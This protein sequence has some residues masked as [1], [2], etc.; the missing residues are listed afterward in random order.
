M[1]P[2]AITNGAVPTAGETVSSIIPL[3]QPKKAK[4]GAERSRAYRQRKRP[5]RKAAA[6]T[7]DESPSSE[8]L[9]PEGFLSADRAFAEPAVALPPT[10]PVHDV[11]RDEDAPSRSI[12]RILLVA[13]ALAL[14]AVG[15]AMNGWFARSLGASDA[16]GWLFLAIGVAADLVALVVPSCA[17]G[18]WQARHRAASLAGWAVWAMTFLF[19]VTAGIGFASTNISDVTLTRF[20]SFPLTL[21]CFE[22][23]SG[24]SETVDS[25]SVEF[26][27][28]HCHIAI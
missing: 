1:S 24:H 14:A 8:L 15:I 26:R 5:K 11:A 4:S 21:D 6:P 3:H 17:A 13:A 18:L 28:L 9:I 22:S 12:S 27:R 7:N 10:M 16:A 2:R 23:T 25:E 20:E 19:A